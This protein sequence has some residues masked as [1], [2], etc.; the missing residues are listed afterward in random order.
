MVIRAHFD[1]F[2]VMKFELCVTF[3]ILFLLGYGYSILTIK[4]NLLATGVNKYHLL[5]NGMNKY[6]LLVTC[7]N[8]YSLLVTCVNKYGLLV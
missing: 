4:Y 6:S 3:A 1:Y 7:V 5:V 2:S 8:K